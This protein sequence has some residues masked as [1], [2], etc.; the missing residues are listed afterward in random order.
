MILPRENSMTDKTDQTDSPGRGFTQRFT[1]FN[2]ILLKSA[3]RYLLKAG[4]RRAEWEVVG[5]GRTQG[6]AALS[7]FRPGGG[8]GSFLLLGGGNQKGNL[9]PSGLKGVKVEIESPT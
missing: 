2:P 8:V 5:S 9:A 4:P 7:F 1:V 3:K 6:Q